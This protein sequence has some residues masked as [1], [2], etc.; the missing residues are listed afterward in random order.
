MR[1]PNELEDERHRQRRPYHHCWRGA[2]PPGW[3]WS[4]PVGVASRTWRSAG[5]SRRPLRRGSPCTPAWSES[6]P[7]ER[8]EPPTP[9]RKKA[10]RQAGARNWSSVAVGRYVGTSDVEGE[11]RGRGGLAREEDGR[12]AILEVPADL[13]PREVDDA[14]AVARRLGHA[15]VPSPDRSASGPGRAALT[16]SCPLFVL[17]RR[18][19]LTYLLDRCVAPD[20]RRRLLAAG[21]LVDMSTRNRSGVGLVCGD[22]FTVTGLETRIEAQ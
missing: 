9:L 8:Q 13:G 18:L 5:P 11:E 22:R 10:G 17:R 7:Y 3:S 1:K 21:C 20:C 19:G 15:A 14:A 4:T 6:L 2:P 12:V 16:A